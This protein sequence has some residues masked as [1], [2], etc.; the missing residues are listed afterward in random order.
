M[1]DKR[2]KVLSGIGVGGI[3]Q[4]GRNHVAA[5]ERQGSTSLGAEIHEAHLGWGG[6]V[7]RWDDA[8]W[9]WPIKGV[10]TFEVIA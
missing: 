3:Y 7:I 8:G 1:C 4:C 10:S 5:L 2:I 9:Q 6:A